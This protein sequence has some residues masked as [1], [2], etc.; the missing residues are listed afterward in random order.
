MGPARHD[1]ELVHVRRSCNDRLGTADDDAVF[2]PLLDVNIDVGID[3]PAGTLGPIALRVGHGNAER[4]V[5][6]LNIVKVRE[7]ALAV[8]GAVTIVRQLCR[9]IDAIERIVREVTLSASRRLA[10]QAHSLELEEQILRGL[11]DVQHPV[12][13]LPGCALPRRHDR[14]VLLPESEIVG[15]PHAGDARR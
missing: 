3:L 9:L 5:V 1:E 8:V 12:D 10:Y 2:T 4:K 7:E 15:D 13:G 14:N 6:I 11:V